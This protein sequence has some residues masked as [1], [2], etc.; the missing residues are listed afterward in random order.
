MIKKIV[1]L[2]P[3]WL[4]CILCRAQAP[5]ILWQKTFGGSGDEVGEE[6]HLSNNKSYYLIGTAGSNDGDVQG[7]HAVPGSDVWVLKVDSIHNINSQKCF[8][9]ILT[10][11]G[12]SCIKVNESFTFLGYSYF[13]DGDVSGSHNNSQD[14]WAIRTDSA[15]NL[16]WQRCYGSQGVEKPN[17]IIPTSDGNFVFVGSTDFDG[18]D[19]V[20]NLGS[21]NIWLVKIDSTNTILW[22]TCLGGDQNDGPGSVLELQ[23]GNLLVYGGID[24][25]GG[26][27]TCTNAGTV[28]LAKLN[29]N[30]S[31]LW[32]RCYPSETGA[33]LVEKP[34]GRLV[35]TAQ[36]STSTIP[37]YSGTDD[38]WIYETDSLGNVL[39]SHAYGGSWIDEPS[40]I[41]LCADGGVIVAGTTSSTDGLASGTHGGSDAFI[42]KLDSS[43]IMEW[44]HCYGGSGNDIATSIVQDVD[45]GFIFTGSTSSTDGDITGLQHGGTDLWLVKLAPTQSKISE[46]QNQIENL[47]VTYNNNEILISYSSKNMADF[48]FRLF[49]LLGRELFFKKIEANVGINTISINNDYCPGIKIIQLQSKYSSSTLKFLLN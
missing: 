43:G 35:F 30:G 29:A 32:D 46:L 38:F 17:R 47:T 42:V 8:G 27:V 48:Y 39:N 12:K 19:V 45:G 33:D 6:V 28:W 23:D 34:D 26:I 25:H 4:V 41:A 14:I 2:S 22:Q 40:S 37:G 15:F 3:I 44:S 31:F 11:K 18:G 21:D 9:G 10:E 49:D 16:Q 24:S 1:S 5:T 7:N 20:C 13:D 36:T